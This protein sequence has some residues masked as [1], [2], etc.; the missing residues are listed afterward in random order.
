MA[1]SEE[2]LRLCK[3]VRMDLTSGNTER[4]LENICW[5]MEQYPDYAEPHNLMGLLLEAQHKHSAAIKHF[6]AA[7][8]LDPTYLPARANM[9]D[10]AGFGQNHRMRFTW[11]DCD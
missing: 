9:E 10:F 4:C 3:R 6:R 8:A 7:Y 11:D 2:M 1:E 5:A